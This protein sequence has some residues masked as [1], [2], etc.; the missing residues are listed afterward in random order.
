MRFGVVFPAYGPYC[1]REFA[2]R[3][4][5]EAERRGAE[6]VLVWDHYM[7]PYG[8]QTFDAYILL[9]YLAARTSRIRLGTCVTP[10]PFRNPAMLAKMIATLDAL[11]QGRTIV[12]VGAGW[13]WPEFDA[14][15]TWDDAGVRVKKTE[16]ALKLMTR[17][18]TEAEVNFE[19]EF[20]SAK[21]AVL[22]PKPVQKPHPPLWFG[23]TGK[24]MLR[25]AAEYG[26]GWIPT[27]ISLGE[28]EKYAKLLRNLLPDEKKG[29][30]VFAAQ[31]WPVGDLSKRIEA[32]ERAGCDLYFAVIPQ[33]DKKAMELLKL[34]ARTF[35]G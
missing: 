24:I 29:T 5:A 28:Y 20:Y 16:E 11:S 27:D 18:W 26:G 23:T 17:L 9:S 8:N 35:E 10:F 2:E 14:Y 34:L 15:S 4:V 22:E 32:Y 33:D 12:G 3:F 19:G 31:D 7:L 13:H 21:G 6:A 25:L 30:F 1:N